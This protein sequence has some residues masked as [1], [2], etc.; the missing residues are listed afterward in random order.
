MKILEVTFVQNKQHFKTFKMLTCQNSTYLT[1]K[2]GSKIN[3]EFFFL[4]ISNQLHYF[5]KHSLEE[6]RQ[7]IIR[8]L[9]SN[10]I[11]KR[12]SDVLLFN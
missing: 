10:R 5:C 11:V 12:L 7:K 3:S 6:H 4:N 8:N 1:T 2:N 9:P